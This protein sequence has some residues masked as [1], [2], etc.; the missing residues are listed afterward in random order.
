MQFQTG[1][2]VTTPRKTGGSAASTPDAIYFP[3]AAAAFNRSRT[4]GTPFKRG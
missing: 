3:A 2:P 1:I 4:A